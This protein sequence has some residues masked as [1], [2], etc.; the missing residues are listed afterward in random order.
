VSCPE[1]G[2]SSDI[3]KFP[4]KF[5]SN[6]ATPILLEKGREGRGDTHTPIGRGLRRGVVQPS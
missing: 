4:G 3:L 5:M 2:L 1:L 6:I